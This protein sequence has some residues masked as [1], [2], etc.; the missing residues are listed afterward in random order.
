MTTKKD[1]SKKAVVYARYSSHN[2]QEQSIEGQIAMAKQYAA[3][4]G[5]TIIHEYCDRAKTGT[6]DNR[7]E[8]QRMLRDCAK[9]QFSIIIVW[10]VDRFGRNREEITF[11]KYKAK[12]HGVHVEYVAENIG[13]GPEGVILESV[14]EGMAEYYSL[15]LSQNVRRGLMESA[16]KHHVISGQ[17]TLGYRIGADKSYELDPVTAPIAKKIF[18]MYADGSTEFEIISYLNSQ[19]LRT[20]RG[21]AW[22]RSSLKK[23]LHNE[24]Y[25][26]TYIFKDVIHDEDAIPAIV[27]KET[28]RRVQ[29]RLK[30]NRRMP[31]HRWSHSDYLL[32]GK[33]RCGLCGSTMVGKSGSS[34]TGEKHCYYC[35]LTRLNDKSCSKG[36]IRQDTLEDL[37]LKETHHILDNQEL[38][39]YIADKTWELY[40]KEDEDTAEAD[41]MKAELDSAEK[42]LTNLMKAAEAGMPYDLI[43]SRVAELTAQ[44]DQLKRALAE[45]ELSKGP[46]LTRDHILF[47]LEKFRDGDVRDANCQKRLIETFVNSV[48]LYE[49][50][51]VIAYNYS[52][53]NN[54]VTIE[55]IKKSTTVNPSGFACGR[56][57]RGTQPTDE[58]AHVFFIPNRTAFLIS[59][60]LQDR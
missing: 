3:Q 10:K 51:V 49:D 50:R 57:S 25:I 15:Q 56:E 12:K 21:V 9:H 37:V 30:I 35:C 43:Q 8:F 16:K 14:L 47:F 20:P 34:H 39:E 22:N 29:E 2:Q 32:T 46:V 7:E 33:L 26:G 55:D 40:Q 1:V 53:E 42:G 31:S 27:D 23:M 54:T 5:Y 24:R 4:K 48:F 59:L 28:F 45:R 38:L 52:G 18:E 44:R 41:A 13:Q 36:N 60:W 17:I 6:N 58:P 19:G 11:N